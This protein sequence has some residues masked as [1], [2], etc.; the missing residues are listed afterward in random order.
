[1]LSKYAFLCRLQVITVLYYVA[2]WKHQLLEV[3]EKTQ[4]GRV[5]ETMMTRYLKFELIDKFKFDTKIM[6]ETQ[7]FLNHHMLLQQS[8]RA[9]TASSMAMA[10]AAPNKPSIVGGASDIIGEAGNFF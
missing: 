2:R 10:S 8:R 5:V 4:L 9:G 7:N 1:M 3:L 6:Q